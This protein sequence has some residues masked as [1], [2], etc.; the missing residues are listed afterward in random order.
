MLVRQTLL[1]QF[2]GADVIEDELGRELRQA[3][4]R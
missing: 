4:A 1:T 3:S 2:R